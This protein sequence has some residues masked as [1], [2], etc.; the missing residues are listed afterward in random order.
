VS[1]NAKIEK[2]LAKVRDHTELNIHAAG[3]ST[4]QESH[5]RLVE[6]EEGERP[7]FWKSRPLSPEVRKNF[8]VP[9]LETL[10]DVTRRAKEVRDAG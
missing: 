10:A 1:V 3:W 7:D 4:S 9:V 6:V 8:L 2:L 5:W